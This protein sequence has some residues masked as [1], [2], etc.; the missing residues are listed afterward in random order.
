MCRWTKIKVALLLPSSTLTG[1]SSPSFS[2][3]TFYP[4][5]SISHNFSIYMSASSLWG[6]GGRDGGRGGLWWRR[7]RGGS[8]PR[9]MR[10][11]VDHWGNKGRPWAKVSVDGLAPC[12]AGTHSL[13]PRQV[14]PFVLSPG[15]PMT[16]REGGRGEIN[17]GHSWWGGQRIPFANF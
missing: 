1:F 17:G 3:R 4:S 5:P 9:Q 12:Q 2:S 10:S 11:E 15:G 16:E 8:C 7:H 6:W 13:P 14:W